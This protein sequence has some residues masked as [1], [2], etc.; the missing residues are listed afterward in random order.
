MKVKFCLVILM[1]AMV[2]NSCQKQGDPWDYYADVDPEDWAPKNLRINRNSST[3]ITLEW[4]QDK[5]VEGHSIERK[6]EAAEGYTKVITLEATQKK[7]TMK[8][9][10]MITINT[11]RVYAFA[12]NYTSAFAETSTGTV[13]KEVTNP[14]T[15]KTWMDRNLGASRAATSIT[16]IEAYGDLYQWGRLTDGHEKRNS[17]TTSTLSNSDIPGHGNFITI[18]GIF[19]NWQIQGNDN[20]W[21]GVSGINN[22]CP[23]GYRLP[24]ATE[25]EAER[26]SWSSNDSCGAYASPLKLLGAGIRNHSSGSLND[27]G[28]YGGYWSATI[29]DSTA[30]GLSFFG[31]YSSVIRLRRA[32]GFSV[33]CIKD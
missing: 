31:G 23:P 1:L 18:N 17:G 4:E 2:V 10:D 33:R 5:A 28:S 12:G 6:T 14:V 29:E 30:Q 32:Y 27:V 13:A 15:G 19:A 21:Q 26:Q 11:Y 9:I 8:N 16:D 20:L 7:Y 25:W 3:S 22:P 24:T